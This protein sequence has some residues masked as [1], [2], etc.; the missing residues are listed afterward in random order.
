MNLALCLILLTSELW[1]LVRGS[2]NWV[3]WVPSKFL[4]SNLWRV[5]NTAWPSGHTS[6][7]VPYPLLRWLFYAFSLSSLLLLSGAY[8]VTLPHA[9]LEKWKLSDRVLFELLFIPLSCAGYSHL[10]SYSFLV[11]LFIVFFPT[12][13]ELWEKGSCCLFTNV[14]DPAQGLVTT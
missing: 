8:L 1:S 5:P 9:S 10:N 13:C 7:Q 6:L 3:D 14:Y 2:H 11:F 12:D 4:I